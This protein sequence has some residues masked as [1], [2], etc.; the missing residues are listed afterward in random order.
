MP[1]AQH[2]SLFDSDKRIWEAWKQ[3]H[4]KISR[5][6]SETEEMHRLARVGGES[7]HA[8]LEHITVC[9]ECRAADDPTAS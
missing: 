4:D 3:L 2:Q 9:P 7:S 1:C 5:S 6:V 8:I